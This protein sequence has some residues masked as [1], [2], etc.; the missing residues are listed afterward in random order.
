ME[1]PSFGSAAWTAAARDQWLGWGPVQ[2]SRHLESIGNNTLQ[3]K[4]YRLEHS[5]GHGQQHLSC[6]LAAL[7]ILVFLYHTF[8]PFAA[9]HYRLIRA[10][11][12]TRKTFFDDLRAPDPL[13]QHRQRFFWLVQLTK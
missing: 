3:S 10:A 9:P 1:V 11:W 2:R 12:P 8:L 4:G 13:I 6:L 7:N 5:F